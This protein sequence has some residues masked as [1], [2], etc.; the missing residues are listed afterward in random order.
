MKAT[1]VL[2]KNLPA[3][4]LKNGRYAVT[5]LPG[6]GAKIVSFRTLPDGREYLWQNPSP[7][8]SHTGLFD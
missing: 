5:V 3:V 1:P 6:E 7:V 8:Y 2:Y 4:E